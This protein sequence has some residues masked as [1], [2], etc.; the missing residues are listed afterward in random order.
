[1]TAGRRF[2]NDIGVSMSSMG[3]LR[4][5]GRNCDQKG[6]YAHRRDESILIGARCGYD[7]QELRAVLDEI[8]GEIEFSEFSVNLPKLSDSSA[9]SQ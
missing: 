5:D 9:T 6:Y 1:M 4:P 3:K 2:D 7:L 8:R